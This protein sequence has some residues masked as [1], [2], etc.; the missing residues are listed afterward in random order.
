MT[1]KWCPRCRRKIPEPPL[2]PT[3]AYAKFWRDN[4]CYI[5]DSKLRPIEESPEREAPASLANVASPPIEPQS[6]PSPAQDARRCE[7]SENKGKVFLI[8]K[9]W[10]SQIFRGQ[11]KARTPLGD[12]ATPKAVQSMADDRGANKARTPPH[13]VKPMQAVQNSVD[14]SKNGERAHLDKHG[15]SKKAIASQNLGDWNPGQVLMDDFVVERTLGEGGMGKVYLL[16]SKSTGSQFAV[17]RAKGLE[18]D[19][20]KKFLAEL[21]T[22]IDLPEHANLV[23]CRFFR[24]L[25]DEVL[26]F[27][28]YVE[29]GSLQEWIASRKLYA[30]G[31]RQALERILDVAIQFAWGLHCLHELGL[32]HQDVKPGNV[33]MGA[34]QKASVHGVKP[35]VT[36]YGLAR[37]RATA[38]ERYVP[39]LGRSVLVSC[40]GGTPAYW[41]P[42]QAKGLALTQKT[43]MW[44]WGLSVLEMFVGEVNWMSGV[45]AAEVLAQYMQNNGD[46]VAIPP[47]PADVA[48]LLRRCFRQD[49]ANRPES[50]AEAVETLKAVFGKTTGSS[51][52]RAL[53]AIERVASSQAGIKERRDQHGTEWTDPKVWLEKALRAAGRDPAEAV[54]IVLRRGATRRGELVAEIAIYAD[55]KR[56]YER[57]VRD[58]RRE[59][60]IDLVALCME[61]ALVHLTASDGSGALQECDQT[62]TILERLVN[63]EG[64]RELT[65]NLAHVYTNKA[66]IVSALGDNRGAVALYDQAIAI[67][68]RLVNQEGRRELAYDLAMNYMNKANALLALGNNREAVVLY[69]Q[70]ITIWERLVN[71]EGRRELANE[72]ARIYCNKALAVSALGDNRKAVAL[73]DQAIAIRERLVNQEG[74]RELANDL[75][76]VYRNKANTVSALGDNR[77]AVVLYDQAIAIRERLVNQEGRRELADDLASVY[78][79]KALAVSA[80][81]DN[82]GAV[83]LYDQAIAIRERLVNQ[84]GRRELADD[85]AGAY[86][87]KANTVS[88]LGDNR[89][90]VVLYDQAIAIWERLVNQEGRRELTNNLAHVYTNKAVIVSAL[91]DNRGAVAL[92]DQAIAIMERLVNQEGRRELAGDLAQVVGYRGVAL[93]RLGE[94]QR[95]RQEALAAMDVLRTEVDRT[96]SANL[97]KALDWI[98][99]Q[100]REKA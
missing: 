49:P 20:R 51:Y 79:N 4:L 38:G 74:R 37:A 24:T 76:G 73:Y 59:L 40:G 39:E 60:E 21:Q 94:T 33:L 77:G 71:Q 2:T 15:A 75:A 12:V 83:V 56:L 17:K 10:F 62:I 7:D 85:L 18:A 55:A 19:Q 72:L 92:Y 61:K 36:D 95:G 53:S 87:N 63:Q 8:M 93:V 48:V 16:R 57:L 67:M 13:N 22:W 23:P 1:A 91:G 43:D 14:R 45:S 29:G 52:S 86:M 64:R 44:A 28:E 70:A 26:I 66:V 46:D 3:T 34:D 5:C 96:G 97:K 81:G 31:Q 90:A 47:M 58:G 42:E 6:A 35:M 50:M 41:S 68:E 69:D 30:S 11:N 88:A 99:G 80:L 9:N 54:A 25:G 32:V 84:E 100:V 98:D 65:N 27:A 82:R 89:G 78:R